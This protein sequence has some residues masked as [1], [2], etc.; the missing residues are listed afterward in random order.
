MVTVHGSRVT[1]F[2]YF[3]LSFNGETV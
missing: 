2:L 3:D 1:H